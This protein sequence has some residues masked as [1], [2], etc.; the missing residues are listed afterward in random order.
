MVSLSK[1]LMLLMK[2]QRLRRDFEN[3]F[4]IFQIGDCWEVGTKTDEGLLFCRPGQLDSDNWMN[5]VR[6]RMRRN[7][8]EQREL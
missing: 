3:D 2:T 8:A 6:Y 5:E 7:Y 4:E 1:S